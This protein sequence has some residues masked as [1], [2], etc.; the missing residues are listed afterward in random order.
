[1]ENT[2][3]PAPAGPHPAG[4]SAEALAV[5]RTRLAYERTMM[6]W[7]RT[8][9]SLISF[10]FSIYKFADILQGKAAGRT[11][12]APQAYGSAMILTGLVA[13]VVATLQHR[14]GL[15][16]LRAQGAR[17]PASLASIVAV[18]VAI[19]GLGALGLVVLHQ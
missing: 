18:L 16:E 7:T 14:A 12:L 6:A 11:I 17:I 8:G 9:V 19:L 5:Q 15:Q 1:M 4:L 3:G 13:L 2:T 10:G